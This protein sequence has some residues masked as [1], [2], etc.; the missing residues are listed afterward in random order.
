MRSAR[1][2]TRSCRL[3]DHTTA[4]DAALD[5]YVNEGECKMEEDNKK[6]ENRKANIQGNRGG[7]GRVT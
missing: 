6:N 4:A 5:K 3:A 7:K 2:E 1:E